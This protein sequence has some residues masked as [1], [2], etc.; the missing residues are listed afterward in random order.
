MLRKGYIS[1]WSVQVRLHYWAK[2]LLAAKKLVGDFHSFPQSNG[3]DGEGHEKNSEKRL[4]EKL[5]G[6]PPPPPV[7]GSD[8]CLAM[9]ENHFPPF[10][11]G[12]GAA[13]ACGRPHFKSGLSLLPP[14]TPRDGAWPSL[15]NCLGGVPSARSRTLV[16]GEDDDAA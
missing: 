6:P 4:G 10:S 5:A 8:N 2:R 14:P 1:F 9:G 15:S 3:H 13:R 12:G 7:V 16:G 11:P